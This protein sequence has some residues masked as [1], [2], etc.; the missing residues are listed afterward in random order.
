MIYLLVE[1]VS[2]DR[3]DKAD[4]DNTLAYEN[5]N[6]KMV[7]IRYIRSDY[8]FRYIHIRFWGRKTFM[9]L[10]KSNFRKEQPPHLLQ[11]NFLDNT[12]SPVSRAR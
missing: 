10:H 5:R 3:I 7:K 2:I 8:F 1:S 11:G 4:R 6:K 9:A 12:A